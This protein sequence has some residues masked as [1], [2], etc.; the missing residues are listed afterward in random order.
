[1]S[2]SYTAHQRACQVL[3]AMMAIV[4]FGSFL[5][6]AAWAEAMQTLTTG[7]G[8]PANALYDYAQERRR[9]GDLDDAMHELRKVLLL[10]P[11]HR[12]ARR[13]LRELESRRSVTHDQ[14]IDEART[15]LESRPPVH[16]IR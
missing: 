7:S 9:F 8:P 16:R 3:K 12:Q 10:A 11:Y 14:A 6:L 15:R 2:D 13:E 5:P 4:A 1:M